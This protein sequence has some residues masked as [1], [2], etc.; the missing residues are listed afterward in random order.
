MG[1][2]SFRTI[3]DMPGMPTCWR[4]ASRYESRTGRLP[5]GVKIDGC[6]AD[7]T[8][9]HNATRAKAAMPASGVLVLSMRVY[10]TNVNFAKPVAWSPCQ[11]Q[12][13]EALRG[14]ALART[15][16]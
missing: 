4:K 15:R 8:G 9:M 5:P 7:V 13:K 1:T 6:C 11:G 16:T 10:L 3:A 12:T 2:P 14:E